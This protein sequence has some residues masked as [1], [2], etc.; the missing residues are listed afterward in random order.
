MPVP[1]KISL[2]TTTP[3]EMPSATCQSGMA[4]GRISGKSIPVTRKPSFSSCFR[5]TR[6]QQ[7]PE[8]ADHERHEQDR[9]R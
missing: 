5:T 4:G 6:E 2:P 9:E 8:A 1:P 3:N 7:L